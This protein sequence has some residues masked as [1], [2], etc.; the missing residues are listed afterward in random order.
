MADVLSRFQPKLLPL[1]FVQMSRIRT[2]ILK[3]D[4]FESLADGLEV[5]KTLIE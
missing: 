2:R 1:I 3:I 5:R 4:L